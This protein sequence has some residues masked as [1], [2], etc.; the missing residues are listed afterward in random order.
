MATI[1][2]VDDNAVNRQLLREI[3]KSNH[4]II[5]AEDGEE[6]LSAAQAAHPDLIITDI[7]MPVMDGHEFVQR[8]RA[9]LSIPRCEVI[10]FTAHFNDREV[11][12]LALECG[13]TRILYKPCGIEKILQMVEDALGHPASPLPGPPDRDFDRK[14]RRLLSDKLFQKVQELEHAN[15]ELQV[16]VIERKRIEEELTKYRESLKDLVRER[17]EEL[18]LAKEG[19]EKEMAARKAAE[20]EIIKAQKLEAVGV[21]AAGIAHDFNNALTAIMSSVYAAKESIAPGQSAHERL[22]TAEIATRN[23]QSLARQLLAFSKGGAPVKK[24]VSLSRLLR[25]TACFAVPGSRVRCELTLPGDLWPGSVDDGQIGQAISNV[26]INAEQA[27]P[28]GGTIDVRAENMIVGDDDGLSLDQGRYV[29]ISVADQGGG[30]PA[31]TLPLIFDPYFTTKPQGSGL[32]LYTTYAIVKKHGGHIGVESRV[33]EGTV[34][35]IYLPASDDKPA[36][37]REKAP[38]KAR[39]GASILIMEDDA[40]VANSVAWALRISGFRTEIVSDGAMAIDRYRKSLEDG[41]PFDAVIMDL[42]IAGGMGGQEAIRYLMEIDPDVRAIVSSGYSDAPV[43]ANFSDFGFK[44]V[45]PKP[46]ELADL[47]EA[48]DKVLADR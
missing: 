3:L 45:I 2:I 6:G 41:S 7:L 29:R 23:A 33:G 31:E 8:V 21:L 1:L 43:M 24:T 11:S 20:A 10:F 39:G 26:L 25:E 32:G 48:I 17:T 9:D 14:H 5:E 38:V 36:P 19:L 13:V 42:T 12:S 4:K 28:D 40:L 47:L 46:Y 30:I 35:R 16:E 37:E 22:E 34:F 15:E 18:R 27:M 44:G